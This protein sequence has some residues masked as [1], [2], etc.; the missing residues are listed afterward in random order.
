M[1][2][3]HAQSIM[4]NDPTWSLAAEGGPGSGVLCYDLIRYQG[5]ALGFVGSDGLYAP[6]C[7]RLELPE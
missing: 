2:I 7:G 3:G 6:Q 5:I 4:V 1:I